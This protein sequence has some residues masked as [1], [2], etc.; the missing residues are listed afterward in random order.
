M[1]VKVYGL[2]NNKNWVLFNYLCVSL[3]INVLHAKAYDNIL[4]LDIFCCTVDGITAAGRKNKKGSDVTSD[5]DIV[6][7]SNNIIL[8]GDTFKEISIHKCMFNL[9]LL[10]YRLI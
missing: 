6:D 2:F 4:V 10:A 5:E 1:E 3:N 9:L 8:T 7:E